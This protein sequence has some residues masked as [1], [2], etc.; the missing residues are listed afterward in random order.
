MG[1]IEQVTRHR[2]FK[3]NQSGDREQWPAGLDGGGSRAAVNAAWRPELRHG[4]SYIDRGRTG[5]SWTAVDWKFFGY[6]TVMEE[7]KCMDEEK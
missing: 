1:E 3:A 5:A 2:R 7:E 4:A 6:G